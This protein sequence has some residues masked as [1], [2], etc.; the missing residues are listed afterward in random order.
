[1]RK[2][3]IWVGILFLTAMAGS[4]VGGVAFVEPV[5]TAKS[6]LAAASDNQT[7]LMIGVLLE[8]INGIAVAGIGILMYPVFRRQSRL[9]AVGYL[10]LRVLEAVFCCL[11]VVSPVALL[12]LS[13]VHLDPMAA[14][15]IIALL[16]AQRG[17]ISG[18][19][20]PVFFSLA[21]LVFYAS[22]LKFKLLPSWISLWGLVGAVLILVMNLLLTFQVNLGEMAML[23]ALP[24]ITNEIFL[25]IWLIA[26]GFELKE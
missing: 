14:E 8:L 22:L 16:V 3:A 11:I 10:A 18:L 13:G 21:A 5:L 12:A 9:S 20:L 26:K 15:A 1:M 19:L 7:G 6:P 24:I 17:A 23:F 2:I 4:L 25:G